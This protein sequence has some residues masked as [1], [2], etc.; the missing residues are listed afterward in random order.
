MEHRKPQAIPR[1]GCDEAKQK[2]LSSKSTTRLLKR[3]LPEDEAVM[4][5]DGRSYPNPHGDGP[6]RLLGATRRCQVAVEQNK[7]AATG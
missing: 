6:R 4:F 1:Q 7:R 3:S 5:A 2:G